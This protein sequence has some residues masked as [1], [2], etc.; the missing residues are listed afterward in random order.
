MDGPRGSPAEAQTRGKDP[1]Q[2]QAL[3]LGFSFRV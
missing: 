1:V 2:A 3:G